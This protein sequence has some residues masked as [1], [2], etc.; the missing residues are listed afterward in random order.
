L[1]REFVM[2]RPKL[3]WSSYFTSTQVASRLGM[4]VGTLVNWIEH[5]VLPAPTAKDGDVRY[6]DQEWLRKAREIVKSK[7]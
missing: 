5:G 1:L 6:F 7:K 3:S 4:N 2:P